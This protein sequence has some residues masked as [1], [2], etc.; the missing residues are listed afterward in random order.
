MVNTALIDVLKVMAKK[1]KKIKE[2][3]RRVRIKG[4]VTVIGKTKNDN[5]TLTV[6]KDDNEYKFT[7][8]KSHKER[9][10]L[11]EKLKVGCSVSVE[12]IPKFRALICTRLKVLRR[13]VDDAEQTRLGRY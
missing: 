6:V 4:R 13:R 8:V 12:G 7:V 10:A 3:K 11:A 1:E 9:F 5:I 2:Y